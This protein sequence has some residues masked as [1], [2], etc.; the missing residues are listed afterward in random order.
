MLL[1]APRIRRVRRLVGQD[2]A[3]Q[4]VS[5]FTFSRLDYCNS[6]LSRLPRSTIQRLQ[7][8]TNAAARVIMNLSVRDHVKPCV[9]AATLVIRPV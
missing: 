7:R 1:P 4:L 9:E 6:P 2:V 5:A 3:Q 8:A